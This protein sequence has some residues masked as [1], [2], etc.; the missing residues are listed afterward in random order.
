MS[1]RDVAETVGILSEIGALYVQGH[2]PIYEAQW[3]AAATIPAEDM[4]VWAWA[5]MGQGVG[6]EWCQCERCGQVMLM[7]PRKVKCRLTPECEG[8]MQRLAPRPRLTKT[9]KHHLE[10]IVGGFT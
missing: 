9:I 5:I 8:Y 10:S 7:A 4:W 2:L 1:E 6:Q 3:I